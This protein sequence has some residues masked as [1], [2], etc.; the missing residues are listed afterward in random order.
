VVR[1]LR[2]L[3][4]PIGVLAVLGAFA[5]QA[6]LAQSP[7]LTDRAFAEAAATVMT[8][9][10]L[11]ERCRANGG[12]SAAAAKRVVSWESDNQV[13]RIRARIVAL[14]E[15]ANDQAKL[16]SLRASMREKFAPIDAAHSCAAALATTTLPEA[17]FA[18]NNPDMLAALAGT[19]RVATQPSA[20]APEAVAR[21][22]ARIDSFAFDSRMRMGVG[23]ALYPV[24]VPVVLF[25]DG[26][27][28]T[29][30]QGLGFAGGLDA[31]RRAHAA[32]W[33]RWRRSGG[34]LQLQSAE[35]G[36]RNL[37]YNVAYSTLPAGFV[38][39]GVYRSLSGSGTA[40]IGGTDS[41]AAWRD[42]AF[43][44]NGQ[45]VRGGG[46]GAYA[47]I[48]GGSTAVSGIAASRRGRYRIEGI[49]LK[50]QYEDGSREERIIVT[51]P[52]D[53]RAAIW[54]N[55]TGYSRQKK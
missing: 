29:D 11:T 12:L 30:V 46:A 7:A 50:I 44:P 36:W 10:Y 14:S 35:S 33:T 43:A 15:D 38:L 3:G 34:R 28:L 49:V 51:N 31:H 53:G 19:P 18:T 37:A 8:F 2:G 27:A 1:L 32:A 54:L 41:V 55:G 23:G 13:E 25:R 6:A 22:A 40:A 39:D 17:Q 48:A 47:A 52:Q 9:D 20:G 42:Y 21:L 24:P 4:Y 45:V 26:Q 16:Q 5:V